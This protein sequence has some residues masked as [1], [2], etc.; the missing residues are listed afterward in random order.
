M[1]IDSSAWTEHNQGPWDPQYI[2]GQTAG[3][4]TNQWFFSILA[5]GAVIA[6]AKRT[7]SAVLLDRNR[8]VK[9]FPGVKKR[10]SSNKGKSRQRF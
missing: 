2:G 6:A 3:L 7:K 8:N 4:N 10:A 5:V 9:K 1:W